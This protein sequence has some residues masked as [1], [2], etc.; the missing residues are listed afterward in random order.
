ML[1]QKAYILFYIRKAA[2]EGP[3]LPAAAGRGPARAAEQPGKEETAPGSS[4]GEKLVAGQALLRSPAAKRKVESEN[5]SCRKRQN[6]A[7]TSGQ[8]A[9]QPWST[10]AKSKQPQVRLTTCWTLRIWLA[11]LWQNEGLY[12][13]DRV[14][15]SG[16][17]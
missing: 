12:G 14:V 15:C 9:A 3:S 17:V 6:L 2:E 13:A 7:G 5:E 10:P 4:G 1:G 11:A 8:A 16:R